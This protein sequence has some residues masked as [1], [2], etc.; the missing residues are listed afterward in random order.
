MSL[1]R[2]FWRSIEVMHAAV[3]FSPDAKNHYEQIGLRGHWMGYFASRAA[4]L[5]NPPAEVVIAMFH[6]WA[7]TRVHKAIPEAWSLASTESILRARREL[8]RHIIEPATQGFDI[9]DTAKSL[10]AMLTR[11]DWAGKPL[12]AAHAALPSPEHPLDRL[13]FAATAL[14][15]YRGDCHVA[16]LTA[17]GL[18]GAAANA[19]SVATG[20]SDSQ[21]QQKYRG[22]SDDEWAAAY[23]RLRH[24]A[25]VDEYAIATDAGKAARAQIED[26]TDRVCAAGLNEEAKAR[27]ISLEPKIAPIADALIAAGAIRQPDRTPPTGP[28]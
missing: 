10:S 17:A 5:G 2:R 19:L 8:A 24:R 11:I 28:Q 23:E 4:A 22:W 16:I 14:R 27:S 26:A 13:W 21:M 9:D 7:P 15:E 3:Y 1:S 12:A 18:D 25:W 20:R 6:G